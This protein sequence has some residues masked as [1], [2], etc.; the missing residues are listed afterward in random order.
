MEDYISKIGN[1]KL[2]KEKIHQKWQSAMKKLIFPNTLFTQSNRKRSKTK[3]Q[4]EHE[5]TT[6][7][8]FNLI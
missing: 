5:E 4:K 7:V 1:Q 2:T 8:F 3:T 6:K